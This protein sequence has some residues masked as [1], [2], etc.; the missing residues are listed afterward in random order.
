MIYITIITLSLFS[1]FVG[2]FTGWSNGWDERD[3]LKKLKD[4]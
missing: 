3:N 4:L 1:F 2:Y